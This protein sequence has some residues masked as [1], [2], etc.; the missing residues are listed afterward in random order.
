[1]KRSRVFVLAGGSSSVRPARD[2][3][4]IDNRR[5]EAR[6]YQCVSDPFLFQFSPVVCPSDREVREIDGRRFVLR[7]GRRRRNVLRCS[8]IVIE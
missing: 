2:L 4:A 3:S 7:N 1:M 6:E 5:E 8:V